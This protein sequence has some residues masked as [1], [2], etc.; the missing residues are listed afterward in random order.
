MT[1]LIKGVIKYFQVGKN[2]F[3]GGSGTGKNH[4]KNKETCQFQTLSGPK[5]PYETV[6][7]KKIS[8]QDP[9]NVQL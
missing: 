4:R 9:F 1:G 7:L 3:T 2:A 8:K 5:G 6:I